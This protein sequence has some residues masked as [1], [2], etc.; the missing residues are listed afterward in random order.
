[1]SYFS[2][3]EEQ[4]LGSWLGCGPGCSCGPCRS[5]ISGFGERYEREDEEEEL[6]PPTE[7]PPAPLN[8]WYGGYYGFGET[9]TQASNSNESPA[10]E[11]STPAPESRP[12]VAPAPVDTPPT[13]ETPVTTAPSSPE[14]EQE[15]IQDAL[16]NGIR[17]PWQLTDVVFFARHPGRKGT[18][19]KPDETELLS[20]RQHIRLKMV[21]PALRQLR[22]LRRLPIRP[23]LMRPRRI[24]RV[25]RFGFAGVPA[26]P[27][28]GAARADLATI[29]G[30]LT[31]VNN[32]LA[33]GARASARR[34]DLKKKLLDLDVEGMVSAL[35]SYIATGCCEPSLKVL[36]SE[37]KALPWHVTVVPILSRLLREIAAAQGRARKDFKHC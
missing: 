20:E 31:L 7:P 21:L 13:T 23:F 30:D 3:S 28:C 18:P 36:E 37:V 22:S 33:K 12:V 24:R 32:E 4:L 5:G 16:R 26:D 2:S 6:R 10:P 14:A 25:A 27:V 35:D 34:L 17:N 9:E 15:L 11:T 1:M 29:A 19:I 8:G